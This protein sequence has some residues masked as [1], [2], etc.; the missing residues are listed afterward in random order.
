[1]PRRRPRHAVQPVAH[2]DA[3]PPLQHRAVRRARGL[4]DRGQR[5]HRVE[6]GVAGRAAARRVA[7]PR[8]RARGRAGVARR[9]A[10]AAAAGEPG[11]A[12][13]IRLRAAGRPS[14]PAHGHLRA[15]G[16]RARPR[17]RDPHRRARDGHRARRAPRGAGGADR[18]RP[19]RDRG[20]RQRGGHVG[21][22]GRRDGRCVARLDP[23][24][25]PAHRAGGRGWP[26]A[27]A[28]SAVL[29]RSRLPRLRQVRGG[30]RPL[31]RLRARPGRALAGRRP[32][33]A[34]RAERAGRR[35]PLRAAHAGCR[36]ALPVPR[37]RGRRQARVP[38]GCHDAR[39]QSARRRA[40]RGARLLRR[41][42]PLAERL[43]RS[44]RHRQGAR[45]A[46]DDG[47]E[48][49]RPAGLPPVALRRGAPRPAVRGRDRARGLSLL[50]P[51]A[52][53]ARQRRAR[54][55]AAHERAAR[56]H[57]GRRRGLR[58]QERLGARR[59]LPARGSRGG[60]RGRSSAPS[61]GPSRPTPPCSPRSRPRCASASG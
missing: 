56:A 6:P 50:L 37:R 57:A 4:R 7:R 58:G 61:A 48:R 31:R 17:G 16:R 24:R 40:A 22:A 35:G 23:R 44:G 14:R 11:I 9:D 33:G 55:A 26:R 43:R 32:V 45:G 15:R 54:A 53:P 52:L 38:P 47:R 18:V 12:L 51:A 3:L 5:A 39:R 20:R 25:A 10:A 2:D 8:H 1:M 29:P 60:G 21:A 42:R 27:A 28:R 49:A 34:Q 13:R 41:G 59:L 19:D 30:R 46:R 36:A